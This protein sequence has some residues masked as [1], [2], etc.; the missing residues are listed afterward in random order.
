MKKVLVTGATG[1]IGTHLVKALVKSNYSV[2][3]LHRASSNLEAFLNF[4]SKINYI[5]G[6]V[7]DK[8][9]VEQAVESCD[10]VFHLAG[11]ISSSRKDKS[12]MEKINVQGTRNIISACVKFSVQRLIYISSVVTVGASVEPA[13]LNEE[14][15]YEDDLNKLSYFDT[16][17]RAEDL[18]CFA[19]KNQN[20]PAIILNPST[21][22]GE[23]DV[24]KP[25]RKLQKLAAQGHLPF[26]TQGGVSVVGIKAVVEAMLNSI[27][28]GRVGERYILSGENISIKEL[29]KCISSL[30]GSKPPFVKVPQIIFY[31]L[32]VLGDL[33]SY[34]GLSFP[35]TVEKV[36]VASLY[37]WFDSSKAQKEL[38]FKPGLAKEAIAESIAWSK[39]NRFI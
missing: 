37:H 5:L 27:N 38:N 14:S 24:K 23:A 18:V 32:G 1:F 2:F 9:S 10:Y 8:K 12:L 15:V 33:L 28:M 17:K 21:V 3:I 20:L 13:V 4:G 30:A 22:Y 11:L 25:S 6:D 16:K 35:F 36:K 7:S 39:Q 29:L 34:L 19:I 26:Y 31:I